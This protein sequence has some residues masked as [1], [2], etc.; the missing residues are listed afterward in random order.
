MVIVTK[1]IK[2]ILFFQCQKHRILGLV[3]LFSVTYNVYM[4]SV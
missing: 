4:I 3:V 1:F 2:Y